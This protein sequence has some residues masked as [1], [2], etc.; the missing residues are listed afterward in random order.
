[1]KKM[2]ITWVLFAL[3]NLSGFAAGERIVAGG[4]SLAMAGTSVTTCDL[5]SLCNNQAGT[6]WLKGISAGLSFEN[7]FLL[8]E[9]MYE[10]LGFALPSK[11]GTFGLLVNRF[12]N[13]QYSEFK[14]GVSYARKFGKRF[15]IGV[16]LFY[17][18][19]RIARDY[20]NKNLASCEI[21]LIY[22]ADKHLSVG[23]QLLNPVPVKIT[24][25]PC[26]Q[27]PTIICLGLSYGFSDSFLMCAEA[28]K[29]LENPLI[30]RTGAEYH[31]A[32]PAWARIGISTSPFSFTFGFGLE[33]G[34]VKLDMASGYHQELGFSPSGSIT[35]SFK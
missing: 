19:I 23:V 4:R 31:F 20:G 33:F 1:M 29:D 14:A 17:M 18:Q 10:Q 30:I 32:K 11:A 24:V 5:W 35:Y 28:Q 13:S 27:L 12:G 25:Q 9:L 6:A 16:Q 34:R 2:T 21:G 7:R 3:T 26:E 22:K 8:K 15:S